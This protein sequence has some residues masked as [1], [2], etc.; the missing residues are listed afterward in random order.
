[1]SKALPLRERAAGRKIVTRVVKERGCDG[2]YDQR[3]W[4]SIQ[5][6]V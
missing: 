3:I 1:M 2:R 4:K 5:L 6:F